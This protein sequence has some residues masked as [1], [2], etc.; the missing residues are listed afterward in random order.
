M[1]YEL[2]NL[3]PSIERRLGDWTSSEE[4]KAYF[5]DR[6]YNLLALPLNGGAA[7][8]DLLETIAY[9]L[10]L[11]DVWKNFSLQSIAEVMIATNRQRSSAFLAGLP[12]DLGLRIA[13]KMKSNAKHPENAF[14]AAA[15][16]E[17]FMRDV[18]VLSEGF[19]QD[20]LDDN[21]AQGTANLKITITEND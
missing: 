18:Y 6:L 10:T 8:Q 12:H 16:T 3:K 2:F 5:L 20:D 14:P 19:Q 4:G 17:E 7:E 1:R 11:S 13:R 21:A 9:R 15:A